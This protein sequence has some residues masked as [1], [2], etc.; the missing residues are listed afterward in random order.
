MKPLRNRDPKIYRLVST[1]T[2]RGELWLTPSGN[3]KKLIGGIIA[4]YQEIY[5]IEIYSYVF[6][7]NHYHFLCRAPKSNLDLFEEN[8][9]REIARRLN[10]KHHREGSMWARRYDDLEV[11]SDED[12]T[13]AFLYVTTNATR[14]G[15][16]RDMKEWKGLHAYDHILNERGREF[17]FYHYSARKD[18]DKVT[19]HTLKLSILPAFKDMSKDKRIEHMAKILQERMDDIAQRREDAGLGFVGMSV[20]KEQ[21]AGELP[22]S[23]S[24][25]NRPPCYSKRPSNI[26]QFRERTRILR[27]RYNEASKKFRMGELSVVFPEHTFKPTMNRVPLGSGTVSQ[28]IFCN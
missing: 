16:V 23:V 3:V 26:K 12:L 1:R 15:L 10:W 8:V 11:P 22:K 14:H 6:L 17:S 9:N 2:I 28:E 21:V 7:G 4:R 18:E 27:D 20:I 5:K 24:K 13:E 25:S 19:K